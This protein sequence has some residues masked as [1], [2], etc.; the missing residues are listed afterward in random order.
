[1]QDITHA[2]EALS[3]DCGEAKQEVEKS[4]ELLENLLGILHRFKF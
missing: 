2:S 4:N 3:K 1:M